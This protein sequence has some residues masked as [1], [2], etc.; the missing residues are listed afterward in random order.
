MMVTY[1]VTIT[2]SQKCSSH[3]LNQRGNGKKR[4]KKSCSVEVRAIAK[5]LGASKELLNNG[6]QGCDVSDWAPIAS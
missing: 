3:S 5:A 6:G 2:I 1:E 4:E